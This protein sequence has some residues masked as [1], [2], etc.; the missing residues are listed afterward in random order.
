MV[1][2]R[3]SAMPDREAGEGDMPKASISVRKLL[4]TL[5]GVI[6]LR[7]TTVDVR[8]EA[9]LQGEALDLLVQSAVFGSSQVK[10][11]ARWLI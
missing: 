1:R 3:A 8:D 7:G 9:A 4:R 6:A 5:E 11:A 2:G 10:E